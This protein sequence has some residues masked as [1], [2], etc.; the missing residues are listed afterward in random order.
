MAWDY[1]IGPWTPQTA[2]KEAI[3]VRDAQRD[4]KN[5]PGEGLEVFYSP[6]HTTVGIRWEFAPDESPRIPNI[7]Y[8]KYRESD[9]VSDWVSVGSFANP[10]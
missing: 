8:P 10:K 1:K 9:L 7:Y 4:C 2:R 3:K 5:K 6:T